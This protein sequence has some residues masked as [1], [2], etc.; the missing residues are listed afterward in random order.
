[1]LTKPK[2]HK[3]RHS[4]LLILMIGIAALCFV[5]AAQGFQTVAEILV[6]PIERG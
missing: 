2:N 5:L 6:Q 3:A 4:W 1:M